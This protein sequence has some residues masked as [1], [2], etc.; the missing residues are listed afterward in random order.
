MARRL[1]DDGAFLEAVGVQWAT[2]VGHRDR[3]EWEAIFDEAFAVLG[4]LGDAGGD[5]L[6]RSSRRDMLLGAGFPVEADAILDEILRFDLSVLP[7]VPRWMIA[8]SVAGERLYRGAHDEAEP[9]IERAFVLGQESGALDAFVYY[10]NHL[11]FLRHQQGRSDEVV[12]LVADWLVTDPPGRIY[13]DAALA[14]LLAGC[15]RFD[16]ARALYRD[17]IDAFPG[18]RY[19]MSYLPFGA[20]LAHLAADLGEHDRA[21]ELLAGLVP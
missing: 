17:A 12:D 16:E 5:V 13:W 4:R 8:N 3:A 10:G 2:L 14:M 6:W 15:D 1:G 21:P 19:D 11:L 9:L 20:C 7:A 18:H